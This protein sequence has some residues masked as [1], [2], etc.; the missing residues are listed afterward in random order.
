MMNRCGRCETGFVY[1]DAYGE[2]ACLNCGDHPRQLP[3]AIPAAQAVGLSMPATVD[4][5]M[6][7]RLCA[8]CPNPLTGRSARTVYCLE[9]SCGRRREQNRR[10]Q[11][12]RRLRAAALKEA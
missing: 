4:P 3:V 8:T 2:L 7:V 6:P 1:V 11:A 12:V 10:D 9:C 5:S